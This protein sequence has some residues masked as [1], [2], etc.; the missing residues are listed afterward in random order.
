MDQRSMPA[1]CGPRTSVSLMSC[2]TSRLHKPYSEEGMPSWKKPT[3]SAYP[4][5]VR[6]IGS[7]SEEGSFA[8]VL[9]AFFFGGLEN[10]LHPVSK[11]PTLAHERPY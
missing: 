1:F 8:G 5:F 7:S 10:R 6:L 3:I 9:V 11:D 2:A 4:R